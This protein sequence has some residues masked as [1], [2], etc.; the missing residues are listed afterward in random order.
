MANQPEE[1]WDA[2]RDA[3]ACMDAGDDAKA[4]LA[5]MRLKGFG[6]S[7]DE[8]SRQ[9]RAKRAS[10]VLRMFNPKDWGVV[11]WRTAAMT[12]ALDAKN[13]DVPEALSLMKADCPTRK[14]AKDEWDEIDEKIAADVLNARYRS[15]RTTFLPDVADVE[16]AVFGLSFEVS[17][18]NTKIRDIVL[19]D[20]R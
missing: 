2:L 9:Q 11:D 13:W 16:M 1:I 19:S 8:D 15:N 5:I 7:V 4:L 17:P 18:V 12:W 6:A 14:K 3:I 10:A 20:I